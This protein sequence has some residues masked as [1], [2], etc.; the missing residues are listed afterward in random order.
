M[1]TQRPREPKKQFMLF[2][3]S[4]LLLGL[5]AYYDGA[6]ETASP[7]NT[8]SAPVL[9]E[10]RKTHILYGDHKGGGHKHGIGK[11][12]KSEFPKNWDDDKIITNIKTIAANDNLNWKQQNNGYY[13]THKM[14][15]NIKIRVVLNKDKDKIITAYPVNVKR[16]ACPANDN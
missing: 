7:L 10:Q 2:I 8:S 11:A 1:A 14:K 6:F 13:V 5:F 15:E 12:C 9:T 4:V 3:I 16:N